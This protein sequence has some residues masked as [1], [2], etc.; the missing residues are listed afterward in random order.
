MSG[1]PFLNLY[2]SFYR[3]RV[4]RTR[5]LPEG[6]FRMNTSEGPFE[7]HLNDAFEGA[8]QRTL[9]K[10]LPAFSSTLG[11]LPFFIKKSLI[12]PTIFSWHNNCPS[13]FCFVFR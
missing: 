12:F 9:P 1:P 5:V 11:V 3:D 4:A 7:V 6:S 2:L 10:Q 13:L 8:F